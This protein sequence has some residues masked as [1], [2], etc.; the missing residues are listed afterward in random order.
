MEVTTTV[1]FRAEVVCRRENALMWF[2][3]LIGVDG[4]DPLCS[5]KVT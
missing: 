4:W 2:L 3:A 5:G 1:H